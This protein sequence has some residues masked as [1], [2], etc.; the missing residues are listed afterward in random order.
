MF[1]FVRITANQSYLRLVYKSTK[2]N[3]KIQRTK[4]LINFQLLGLHNPDFIRTIVD[5]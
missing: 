3:P 5:L 1:F 4:Y 2:F